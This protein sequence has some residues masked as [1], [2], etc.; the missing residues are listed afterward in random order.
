MSEIERRMGLAQEAM[1]RSITYPMSGNA[2]TPLDARMPRDYGPEEGR[3]RRQIGRLAG[4]AAM[5]PPEMAFA[6]SLRGQQLLQGMPMAE[7]E[8]LLREITR[9]NTPHERVV[10]ALTRR[11]TR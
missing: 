10:D 1:G 6:D 7:Q 11:Q 2:P 5:L 9:A 8:A 4:Y 3:H